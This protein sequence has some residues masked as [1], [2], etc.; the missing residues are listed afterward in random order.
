M[1]C[2]TC[3]SVAAMLSIA[4]LSSGCYTPPAPKR[5]FEVVRT[6][7]DPSF[8]A[9]REDLVDI[10]VLPTRPPESNTREDGT[11]LRRF[12]RLIY[13]ALIA[14]GYSPL[15]LA[16]VDREMA[17]EPLTDRSDPDLNLGRFHEDAVIALSVNEWSKEWLR[18]EDGILVSATLSLIMT[19]TKVK[20]WGTEIR[21][22]LYKIPAGRD[23]R[24]LTDDEA[25]VDLV[26]K[27]L[28]AKLPSRS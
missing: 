14:K 3:G 23:G 20:L 7:T 16:Y 15:S 17:G 18:Q 11:H 21:H 1:K 25:V 13:D 24:N 4:L 27:N 28:L 26:V 5:P 9:A 12:R 10:V 2:L 6:D 19:K 22:R 8:S